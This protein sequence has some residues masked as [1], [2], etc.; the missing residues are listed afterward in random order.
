M[1]LS[2]MRTLV[3]SD[4]HDEDSGNYRWTDNEL[5]RH[6]AKAVKD[7]SNALP[8]EQKATLATTDGSREVSITSLTE[9][10]MIEAVEYP[11]GQYPAS[12]QRFALWNDILTLLGEETPDGSNCAVYYGK[13]HTLDVSGSTIPVQFEDLIAT[14]ACGYAGTEMAGYTINRVNSGGSSTPQDWALW[15]KDKLVFFQSELKRLDYR[16]KVRSRQLYY[17]DS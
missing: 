5:D 17:P 13:L 12:F 1:N 8:L 14:G 4:L 7:F 9:R 6:V 2:D 11:A 15:S 16:N 10:V 3:R